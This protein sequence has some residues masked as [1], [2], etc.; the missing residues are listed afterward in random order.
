MIAGEAQER[1]NFRLWMIM[2]RKTLTCNYRFF[3]LFR[4][5]PIAF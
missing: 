4:L 5:K 2:T 1:P 3:F